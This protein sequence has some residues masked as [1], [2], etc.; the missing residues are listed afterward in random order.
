MLDE[1]EICSLLIRQPERGLERVMDQYMALVYTIVCGKLSSICDDQDIEECVND[2]F[3]EVYK[4]RQ[5]IDLTKGS[6]KTW[7]AVLSKRKAIDVCRKRRHYAANVSFEAHS[8]DRLDAATDVENA[9]I[10]REATD[11]LIHV[12]NSLGEPD[13]QIIIRKYYFCQSTKDI[14]K[15]LGI[16]ENTIDKRAS[17][18]LN[19]LRLSLGGVL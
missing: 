19:R 15:A 3:Y 18:A 6:L 14:S 1:N 7:L 16:K 4:A 10:G 13:S 17:R 8:P 12:I 2:I 5:S 9:I 11:Y